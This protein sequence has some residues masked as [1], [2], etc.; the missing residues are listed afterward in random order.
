MVTRHPMTGWFDP[1]SLARI[2]V[3]VAI[4]TVFGSFADRRELVAAINPVPAT[5]FDEAFNY[6]D[7][8]VEN[9]S[10][11]ANQ[12]F[13]FDFVADTGDGWQPTHAV[14]Q[15]ATQGKLVLNGEDLHR[16]KVL[17]L[18]GDEVYPTASAEAYLERF[19][20]P[21]DEAC[22]E[23]GEEPKSP[24][25]GDMYA[26]P[27][28][29][30]WYDGLLAF[31]H[32]FARRTVDASGNATVGRKGN[33]IAGRQTKQLRS[34]FALKLP[35]DWWI[36]GTD[37]Q[38]EGFIDQPQ[39]DYFSF[40]AANWMAP[41][42][43]LI[44]CVGQPS[45]TYVDPEDPAKAFNSFS[46][47]SRI[48][49]SA[50]GTDG[51]AMDHELKV[52]LTGDAHHYSR[53]VEKDCQYI[54]AGGG[55]AFLHPTHHLPEE[56]EFQWAYPQPNEKYD[57]RDMIPFYD[58]SYTLAEREPVS[59]EDG[60]TKANKKA[61]FP[62]ASESRR[63]ALGNIAF[64]VLNPL[65]IL[66]FLG[67]YALMGWSLERSVISEDLGGF[68]ERVSNSGQA[69]FLEALSRFTGIASD[70][71][72]VWLPFFLMAYFFA[73]FA[74]E[75]RRTWLRS[76]MVIA[77]V[78]GHAA[79]YL[80]ASAMAYWAFAMCIEIDWD[81]VPAYLIV[82]SH[83]LAA[84]AAGVA[85]A[86]V[87]GLYLMISVLLLGKHWNE[88]FSSLRNRHYKNFLRMRIDESGLTIFPIGLRHVPAKDVP[89]DALKPHLIEQP[90]H[91]QCR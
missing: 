78:L 84:T 29:H 1:F 36:W 66:P 59:G 37:S 49:K 55:G 56:I 40:V 75:K 51:K 86:T 35:N 79:T 24:A 58:R 53:Y 7:N 91:I 62:S 10:G 11:C 50:R 69:N 18:G 15:L 47:L 26:I 48:A 3:R 13:W 28:N 8:D 33:I 65:F 43:K 9:G 22:R 72:W 4:S 38:I 44:L 21:W 83:V 82:A 2:G 46:F 42:S 73:V 68:L 23:I 20:E 64:A 60:A 31:S 87:F 32:L 88:A 5:P 71:L 61:L 41:K 12:E 81:N 63:L 45:W 74:D 76:L 89:A 30:D 6:S 27:G 52:V 67:L 85:A 57:W 90:I 25:L 14:A 70:S 17:V 39:V 80:V 54:T 19:R 16:G 34:Y 77:H